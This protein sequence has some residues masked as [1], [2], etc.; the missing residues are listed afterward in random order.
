[1]RLATV[2]LQLIVTFI[3]TASV[4]PPLLFAVPQLQEGRA[5]VAA[6]AVTMVVVFGV[7]MAIWPR[8]RG[9][10]PKAGGN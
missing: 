9:D 6:A 3:I 2:V 7:L 8:R 5:G 4:L 1:M 10:A